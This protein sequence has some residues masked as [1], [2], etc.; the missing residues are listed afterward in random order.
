M[1]RGGKM[2]ASSTSSISVVL[3]SR[4]ID[5]KYA[6]FTFTFKLVIFVFDSL[7]RL[8]LGTLR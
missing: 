3:L 1:E 4:V 2:S 8:I 7:R 6:T 5:I